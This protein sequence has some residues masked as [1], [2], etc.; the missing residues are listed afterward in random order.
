MMLIA[1]QYVNQNYPSLFFSCSENNN[2]T[3]PLLSQQRDAASPTDDGLTS[4]GLYRKMS[5]INLYEKNL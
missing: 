1:V 4:D 5:K 2:K 3:S